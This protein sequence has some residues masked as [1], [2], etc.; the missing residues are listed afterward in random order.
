MNSLLRKQFTCLL[1]GI[2]TAVCSGTAAAQG[3]RTGNNDV[4]AIPKVAGPI[5]ISSVSYPFLTAERTLDPADLKKRGY[6]EEEFIVTGTANVYDWAADGG[7][8]VKTPNV[9]YGT[10]VLVRR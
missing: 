10:R 3:T 5:A 9:P 4:A 8:T 2:A 6:V 1:I 7:L